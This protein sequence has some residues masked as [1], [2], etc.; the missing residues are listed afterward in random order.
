M[1]SLYRHLNIQTPTQICD[2]A[3]YGVFSSEKNNK[4]GNKMNM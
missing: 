2:M 3:W 1:K 4:L